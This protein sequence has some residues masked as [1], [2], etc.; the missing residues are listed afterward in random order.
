MKHLHDNIPIINRAYVFNHGLLCATCQSVI[1]QNI[2][3][4]RWEFVLRKR[5][6]P[7]QFCIYFSATFSQRLLFADINIQRELGKVPETLPTRL[8]NIVLEYMSHMLIAS[9][10]SF[11]TKWL[12]LNTM[13]DSFVRVNSA[14]FKRHTQSSFSAD[15]NP[16]GLL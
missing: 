9:T 13:C 7:R 2:C 4:K 10:A 15:S 16:S 1:L 8:N 6:L 11:S 12:I 14:F 3:G 5:Y